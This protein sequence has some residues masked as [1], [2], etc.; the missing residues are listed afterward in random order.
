MA[1]D[2]GNYIGKYVDGDPNNF[3]GVWRDYLKIRVSL[4]LHIPVKR[5]MKLKKAGN[6]WCWVNFQYE[7]I[8]TFCF[9]CGMIGHGEKFCDKVFDTPV[10]LI[11][12]PYGPWLRA[13]PKRKMHTMGA[14]WLRSGGTS[15]ARNSGEMRGGNGDNHDPVKD[16]SLPQTGGFSG[17]TITAGDIVQGAGKG[18]NQGTVGENQETSKLNLPIK[19]SNQNSN[20]QLEGNVN[21]LDMNEI[22]IMD[23]KRRRVDGPQENSE[24]TGQT[25]AIHMEIQMT[26]PTE[27]KNE[28]MAS[29]AL[30]TRQAL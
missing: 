2:I 11:E 27:S 17:K 22:S 24:N 28:S 7:S 10:E 26:Q 12:K 4:S 1:T 14:R 5:R 25:Q 30:Q 23:P 29:A 15:Q 21:G 13:D 20:L 16:G 18:V 8:P 6:E 19:I 9:I 3:I